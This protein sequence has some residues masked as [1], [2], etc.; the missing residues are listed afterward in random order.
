MS[1]FGE[2]TFDT[3]HL[4]SLPWLIDGR[5]YTPDEAATVTGLKDRLFQLVP[6]KVGTVTSEGDYNKDN[7]IDT[8]TEKARPHDDGLRTRQEGTVL[9]CAS[10][11]C[12]SRICKPTPV[13]LMRHR[14]ISSSGVSRVSIP[15]TFLSVWELVKRLRALA[16]MQTEVLDSLAIVATE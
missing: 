3:N 7:G 5:A 1:S 15:G 13:G 16:G 8:R 4:I 12:S 11:G 10:S 14:Y 2:N 6:Q 9:S